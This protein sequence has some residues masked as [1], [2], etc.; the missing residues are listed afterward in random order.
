[1]EYNMVSDLIYQQRNCQKSISTFLSKYGLIYLFPLFFCQDITYIS[2]KN[3][4]LGKKDRFQVIK[5]VIH[6]KIYTVDP[7]T[8]STS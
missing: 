2:K 8:S 4:K 1:M 7:I 3:S 5:Q 6:S